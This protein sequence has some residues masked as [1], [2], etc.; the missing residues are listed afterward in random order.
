MRFEDIPDEITKLRALQAERK[1]ELEEVVARS[2]EERRKFEAWCDEH[3]V[4]RPK[5]Q[6]PT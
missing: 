6:P 1:R 4:N 3:D 5:P 2:Q